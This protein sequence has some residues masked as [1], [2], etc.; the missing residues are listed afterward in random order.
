MG[1]NYGLKM[2]LGLKQYYKSHNTNNEPTKGKKKKKK[3]NE[4]AKTMWATLSSFVSNF[5]LFCG[6]LWPL[7]IIII[8]IIIIIRERTS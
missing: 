3:A 8:I 6:H 2:G 1:A 4:R 5:G 7:F